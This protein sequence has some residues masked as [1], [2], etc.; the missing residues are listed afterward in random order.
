MCFLLQLS[1][2]QSAV[3]WSASSV[4]LYIHRGVRVPLFSWFPLFW[5]FLGQNFSFFLYFQPIFDIL[6]WFHAVFP[7]FFFCLWPL[8]PLHSLIIETRVFTFSYMMHFYS[9]LSYAFKGK[10][11]ME[12]VQI[13][14]AE[15]VVYIAQSMGEYTGVNIIITNTFY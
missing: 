6:P 15:L 14:S 11:M 3:R 9:K 10:K 2:F 1:R 4:R 7:H 5:K 13:Q 12:T 8:T